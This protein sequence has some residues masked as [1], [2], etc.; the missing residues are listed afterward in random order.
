MLTK[1]GNE[2]LIHSDGQSAATLDTVEELAIVSHKRR[3]PRS[4]YFGGFTILS[5][6]GQQFGF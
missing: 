4:R 1:I 5:R 2:P 3:E 6:F